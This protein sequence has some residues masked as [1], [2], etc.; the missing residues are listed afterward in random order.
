[1]A[2]VQ[3]NEQRVKRTVVEVNDRVAVCVRREMPAVSIPSENER[4]I[5]AIRNPNSLDISHVSSLVLLCDHHLEMQCS[6]ALF[7]FCV[8]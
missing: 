6:A 2:V 3:I 5:H 7:Y 4:L 1:M 8:C